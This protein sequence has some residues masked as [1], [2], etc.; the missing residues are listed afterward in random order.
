MIHTIKID[1][2]TRNGKKIL[3]DLRR[4][5][6]GVEFENP[7]ITGKIPEGYMTSDEFRVESKKDLDEICRKHGIL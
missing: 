1:D 2:N 5:R 3:N 4:Y 7:A 6:S